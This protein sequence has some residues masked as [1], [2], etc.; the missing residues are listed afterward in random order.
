MTT[1]LARTI[2]PCYMRFD[3]F[4]RIIIDRGS[5]HDLNAVVLAQPAVS[6]LE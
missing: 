4:R 5:R 6:R 3:L 2:E 1:K